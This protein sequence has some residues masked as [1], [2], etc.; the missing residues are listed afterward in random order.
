MAK[1]KHTNKA[2]DPSK[3]A[4]PDADDAND[5]N[6]KAE[7]ALV[8]TSIT[9]YLGATTICIPLTRNGRA[10]APVD[11]S[12]MDIDSIDASTMSS[13]VNVPVNDARTHT[14][15]SNNQA[16]ANVLQAGRIPPTN[17]TQPNTISHNNQVG[18]VLHKSHTQPNTA[19]SNNQTGANARKV[20]S[21]PTSASS[22][23]TAAN[24]PG[25]I[26]NITN[27]VTS[28]TRKN[29][30]P[31]S[32]PAAPL[33]HPRAQPQPLTPHDREMRKHPNAIPPFYHYSKER[34]WNNLWPWMLPGRHLTISV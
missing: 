19:S 26:P 3:K 9:T 13:N 6:A 24:L 8:T 12:V 17:H 15:S 33:A 16:G 25:V 14:A 5:A 4:K 28:Y 22:C 30:I 21:N 20:N 11:V 27:H 23:Q 10:P 34:E 2:E 1:K 7:E 18:H 31:G 32:S 29:A